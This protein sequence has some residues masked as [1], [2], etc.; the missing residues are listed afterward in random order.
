MVISLNSHSGFLVTSGLLCQLGTRKAEGWL[1]WVL[2]QVLSHLQQ[3]RGPGLGDLPPPLPCIAAARSLYH[4]RWQ[5]K[6]LPFQCQVTH[7][8]CSVSASYSKAHS[9][10]CLLRGNKGHQLNCTFW[11]WRFFSSLLTIPVGFAQILCHI[12]IIFALGLSFFNFLGVLVLFTPNNRLK[13]W[14]KYETKILS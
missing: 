5:A 2:L 7:R 12:V 8:C 3:L 10:L 13:N 9:C 1:H 11:F 4:A 6:A 14:S